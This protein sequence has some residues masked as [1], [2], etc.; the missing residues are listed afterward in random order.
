MSLIT[1]SSVTGGLPVAQFCGGSLTFFKLR[2]YCALAILHLDMEVLLKRER[3]FQITK[4]K[5]AK[6]A[7]FTSLT[8]L[9]HVVSEQ[10][11]GFW[12]DLL[13]TEMCPYPPPNSYVEALTPNV[14]LF[15][16]GPLGG[17]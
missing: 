4:S 14:M 17:D 10:L 11:W 5:A 12:E 9:P 13:W 3:T 8:H 16:W 7:A 6:P 15:G 1:F 2:S